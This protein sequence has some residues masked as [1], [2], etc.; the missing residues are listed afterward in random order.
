[1]FL[2]FPKAMTY[3]ITASKM[4]RISFN[5][6]SWYQ[7]K[8]IKR[9]SHIF[10]LFKSNRLGL[11]SEQ[12]IFLLSSKTSTIIITATTASPTKKQQPRKSWYDLLFL[13]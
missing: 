12:G 11:I 3:I 10:I 8:I 4:H 2:G 7:K 13:V 9:L 1:L 5:I 6:A